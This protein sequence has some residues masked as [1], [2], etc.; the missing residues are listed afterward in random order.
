LHATQRAVRISSAVDVALGIGKDF[1]LIFTPE[2]TAYRRLI[3][4][5]AHTGF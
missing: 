2:G 1:T 3:T 4:E 5:G